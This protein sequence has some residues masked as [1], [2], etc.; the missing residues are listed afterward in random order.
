MGLKVQY[1]TESGLKCLYNGTGTVQ[2]VFLI[3]K[4][5]EAASKWL[6]EHTPSPSGRG[7]G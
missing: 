7:S 2:E 4:D 3:C 5:T 1:P 6:S